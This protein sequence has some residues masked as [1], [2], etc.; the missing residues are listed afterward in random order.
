MKDF[1]SWIKSENFSVDWLQGIV[2]LDSFVD[3]LSALTQV[4]FHPEQWVYDMDLNTRF[5]RDT[6]Y[7]APA[8]RDIAIQYNAA[9]YYSVES[10]DHYY[11]RDHKND[12]HMIGFTTKLKD[13]ARLAQFS[14]PDFNH[15]SDSRYNQHFFIKVTGDGMRFLRDRFLY[16]PFFKVLRALNFR[17]SRIDLAFDIYEKD[18]GIVPLLNAAFRYVPDV[19]YYMVSTRMDRCSNIV[20]WDNVYDDRPKT[21]SFH[22]GNHG[23]NMGMIRLYDKLHEMRYGRGKK[24]TSDY[25]KDIDYWFRYEIEL[26]NKYASSVFN[27]I[28]DEYNFNLGPAFACSASMF[29]SVRIANWSDSNEYRYE[30]VI[31]YSDFLSYIIQNIEFAEKFEIQKRSKREDSWRLYV[32][33]MCKVFYAI[34]YCLSN[35]FIGDAEDFIYDGLHRMFA[36]KELTLRCSS[37]KDYYLK[38]GNNLFSK[39]KKLISRCEAFNLKDVG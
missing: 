26:H 32:L 2:E 34:N 33:N 6:F 15:T 31:L 13:K 21:Q 1:S 8:G 16:V 7:Y 10:E 37:F 23:S 36:D 18:N 39:D 24:I 12:E 11:W 3:L 29:F 28:V 19:S 35:E 25:V 17:A 4:G 27:L 30:E 22:F 14:C 5:Y 38:L 20:P 9:S